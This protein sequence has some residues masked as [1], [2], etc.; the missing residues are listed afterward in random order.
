MYANRMPTLNMY[1][2]SLAWILILFGFFK[3]R[4]KRLHVPLVLSG[5]TM[6]FGLVLYLQIT[7]DAIQK[8]SSGTLDFL[9]QCHILASST[10][11]L[12]YFPVMFL[13]FKILK[14]NQSPK[15]RTWHKSI[16]LYCLFFRTLGFFLMF[17]MLK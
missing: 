4:E 13:G 14:G 1:I 5:I 8:A 2:A 3:R 11:L 17:S 6:D 10:A 9:P 12:L 16:A 15:L 7:R